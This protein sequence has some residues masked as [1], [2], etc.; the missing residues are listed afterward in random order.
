MIYFL[1]HQKTVNNQFGYI[2]GQSD[3]TILKES[4]NADI[5]VIPK[6]I[7]MVYSSPSQRCIDTLLLFH[8]LQMTPIIDDRLHERNMGDFENQ[9]RREVYEQYPDLFWN[10]NGKIQF[11]FECT[12]P[13]GESLS[14]FSQRIES[15]CNEVL[16]PRKEQ[17]ILICSHNQAMKMIYFIINGIY[18]S[19]ADWKNLTFP[20]G[21]CVVFHAKQ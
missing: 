18:P 15:F 16:I 2:S 20:N 14:E 19:R 3:S 4:I 1:R 21:K 13:N 11:R 10:E 8:G 7:D 12:P 5:C 9:S 6:C 17:N